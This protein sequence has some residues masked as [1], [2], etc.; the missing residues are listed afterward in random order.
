MSSID[1]NIKEFEEWE[2]K[3]IEEFTIRLELIEGDELKNLLL[4]LRDLILVQAGLSTV[5]STFTM[6]KMLELRN[7]LRR[8][9]DFR[10]RYL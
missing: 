9:K 4:I 7:E 1:E 8:S 10:D 3:L 6:Q 2:K 5:K